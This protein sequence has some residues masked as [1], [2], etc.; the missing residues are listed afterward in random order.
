VI[1]HTGTLGFFVFVL[2]CHFCSLFQFP[3]SCV[4]PNFDHTLFG[5]LFHTSLLTSY[6]LIR[7]QLMQLMFSHSPPLQLVFSHSPRLQLVFSHS[8]CLICS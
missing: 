6:F 1:S 7:M 3:S 4:S 8:P 2:L 5:L